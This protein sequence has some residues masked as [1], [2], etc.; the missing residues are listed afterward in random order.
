MSLLVAPVREELIDALSKRA[1]AFMASARIVL[2]LNE[3]SRVRGELES[4]K[5][6]ALIDRALNCVLED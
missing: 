4:T 5:A 2:G 1:G 6:N 3:R